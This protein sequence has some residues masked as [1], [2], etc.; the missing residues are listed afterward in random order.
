MFRHRGAFIRDLFRTKECANAQESKAVYNY[1][2]TKKKLYKT[3]AGIK[4]VKAIPV[5]TCRGP[6]VSRILRLP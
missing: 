3:K 4:K 1:K 2:N 6:E 5:Q